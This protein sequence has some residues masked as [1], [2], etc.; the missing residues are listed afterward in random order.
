MGKC[1]D[2]PVCGALPLCASFPIDRRAEGWRRHKMHPDVILEDTTLR[3]GEQAPGVAFDFA[4]KMAILDGL[5]DAGVGWIEVGIPAMGGTE[6]EFIKAALD[7]KDDARL[8]VWNRG[9]R[10]DVEFS[11]SL[12]YQAIHIGLPASSLHLD[13]SV[14]KSRDWLLDTATELIGLV[15]QH[16]VFASISAEDIARTEIDFLV[17]YGQAVAEAGADRL[18]LSDTIGVLGPEAYAERVRA[19]TDNCDIDV[20]CHAHNDFGLGLANTL[21][22][23]HAG[24]RY[25][26]VTVNGMGERAG[27]ADLA[28]ATLALRNI[29]GVDLGIRTERLWALRRL[30][31]EATQSPVL[32]WHPVTGSNVFSHES[33][34]HVKAMLKDTSTF[35]PFAPEQVGGERRYVLGKHSGRALIDLLLR[36]NG[37][38]PAKAELD[39]ALEWVREQALQRGGPVLADELVKHYLAGEADR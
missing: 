35:E 16:G 25:F 22:G 39:S 26:H 28:A 31:E 7:R 29:Y 12:G 38:E 1:P 30:V 33:G 27:M 11:L 36:E 3:D 23:L 14:G 15:K 6:L 19:V 2:V 10:A 8:V 4:K 37:I 18:R 32:P 24:A 5:I 20:Q 21:A 34:I 9:V 17:E 13:K